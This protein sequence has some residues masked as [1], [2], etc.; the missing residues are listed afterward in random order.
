MSDVWLQFRCRDREHN[1]LGFWLAEQIQNYV[2]SPVTS[3]VVRRLAN[4][5]R[6]LTDDGTVH[7]V[8]V[9]LPPQKTAWVRWA[10]GHDPLIT[11]RS[12]L[13]EDE[14]FIAVN[15]PRRLASHATRERLAPN[16][17]DEVR[18]LLF[19]R[20]PGRL[21]YVGLLHRLD[22]DT[23]GV[24]LLTKDPRCNRSL[25]KQFASGRIRKTYLCGSREGAGPAWTSVAVDRPLTRVK[26]PAMGF[27]TRV[28][29]RGGQPARTMLRFLVE[30][31]DL[32]VFAAHPET[33]RTHQIRVH[34]QAIGHPILGDRLYGPPSL[35]P[36]GLVPEVA[37]H[38]HAYSLEFYHPRRRVPILIQTPPPEWC[39]SAMAR[40]ASRCEAT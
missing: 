19:A 20:A 16:L 7:D 12:V 39:E 15:K 32:K 31:S 33:G 38:L 2:R 21:P 36:A 25:S 6:L 18:N 24:L 27:R 1:S 3:D 28:A 5:G 13:F 17:F 14:D 4:A 34:M 26:D 23:S 37:L 9:P 11:E 22:R 30:Q 40:L 10:T 35:R 29:E 8:E